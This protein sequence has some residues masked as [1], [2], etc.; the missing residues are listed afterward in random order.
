MFFD[1]NRDGL[2][3]LFLCNVGRYTTEEK[4]RGGYYVGMSDGF[5]GHLHPERNEPCILYKNLGHNKLQDVSR[6]AGLSDCG[7]SGDA[8]FADLDHDGFPDLY[9]LNMQGNDHYYQNV[10]GKYFVDKTEQYFPETPWGAVGIKFFDFNNDGLSDLFITDMHS[11]MTDDI[12]YEDYRREKLKS[13]MKWNNSVLVG[14][15]KSIWG[16]AFYQNLGNGK[17]AEISDQIGVENYRPWG[18]SVDDVN[19]DGFQDVFITASM[20]YMFRYGINSLLLND[21]GKRFLDGEF[22][23]GIEPRRDEKTLTPWFDVDCSGTDKDYWDCK[24]R[25]GKFTVLG[26]LGSRS[27]A[28][29]DFDDDG[30]L[31]TVTKRL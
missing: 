31:D 8:S 29:F 27:S 28:I 11:D 24:D 14:S 22:I 1:Y 25:T 10:G 17:F 18:V 23:L 30:D 12:S 7:W 13:V 19:A 16:N 6:A 26:A 15:E 4:G 2:L 20:N 9:V 21:S 5:T 3:D